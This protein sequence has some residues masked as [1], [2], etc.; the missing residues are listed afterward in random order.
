VL[1]DSPTLAAILAALPVS[2]TDGL[3]ENPC[4]YSLHEFE[5]VC[6]RTGI[7]A[8]LEVTRESE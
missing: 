7:A 8:R 1:Q 5:Q 4:C 3:D 2:P 6:P